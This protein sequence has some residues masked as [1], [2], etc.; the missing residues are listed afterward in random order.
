MLWMSSEP[1]LDKPSGSAM[2]RSKPVR[3]ARNAL[4]RLQPEE[5]SRIRAYLF[6]DVPQREVTGGRRAWLLVAYTLRRWLQVDNATSLA[7]TLSLQ[8]LLSVV[9]VAGLLLTGVGLLGR[10]SGGKLLQQI[11]IALIPETDRA[12][13]IADAVFDLANNIT[14]ERL[15]LSGFL[16]ALIVASLLFL[17]LEKTTNRIWGV[18]R[19]RSPI[20]KFTMFWTLATLAPLI[21]IYSLAQP[22]FSELSE[23]SFIPTPILTTGVGLVLLNRFMPIT[24]VRW[25]AAL[26]GGVLSA[27]LFEVGKWGFGG[28]LTVVSHYESVYGSLSVLPVFTVWTYVSWM[29]VLLGV[30]VAFVFQHY[31][32]VK[33]EGFVNPSLRRD[34]M[35]PAP[36]S[37]MAL[38]LLL[39]ICDHYDQ[40]NTGLT[41]AALEDRYQLGIE[42]TNAILERLGEAGF[43]LETAAEEACYVPARPLDQIFVRDVMVLFEAHDHPRVRREDTLAKFFTRLDGQQEQVFGDLTYHELIE[44]S[45]RNREASAATPE[46]PG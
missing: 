4:A 40:C 14:V 34:L 28:Y 23:Q 35:R 27:L 46:Q 39:A 44:S 16:S 9:P 22:V 31:D 15:G 42:Q 21:V 43:L 8:T 41:I 24:P 29:L 12:A 20:N 26:C 6:P 7:S 45:R 1:S 18:T 17:T 3:V 13:R 30:E 33:K 10:D 32:V 25:L 37:R 2:E 11:A 38:R 5:V 36:T 19:K